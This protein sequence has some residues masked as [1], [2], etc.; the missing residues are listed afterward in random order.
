[1]VDHQL[2]LVTSVDAEAGF[3]F[4]TN[5]QLFSIFA[6]AS[7]S[8]WSRGERI[9]GRQVCAVSMPEMLASNPCGKFWTGTGHVN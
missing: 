3:L 4:R 1:M 6:S 5:R 7:L 9:Q 2:S 8:S